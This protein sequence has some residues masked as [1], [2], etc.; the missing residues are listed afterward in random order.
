MKYWK[1]RTRPPLIY[2]RHDG[3]LSSRLRSS[4]YP[5][6]HPIWLIAGSHFWM[7][8]YRMLKTA[9]KAFPF[10][11]SL[12]IQV[13][14]LVSLGNWWKRWTCTQSLLPAARTHFDQ[15]FW[16]IFRYWDYV[17][18]TA[19]HHTLVS[20]ARGT[21]SFACSE[22]AQTQCPHCRV[23]SGK[24]AVFQIPLV[25]RLTEENSL[26]ASLCCESLK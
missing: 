16:S 13:N 23:L 9:L 15:Q 20:T 14:T 5:P 24:K 12:L 25:K 4:I 3:F 26:T 19:P 6:L 11:E 18:T 8:H 1:S 10:L 21:Y 22:S 17:K 7:C 2:I